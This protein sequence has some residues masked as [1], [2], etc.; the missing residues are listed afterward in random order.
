MATQNPD[1][2]PIVSIVE[3]ALQNGA[4][5]H[6]T[7]LYSLG[8]QEYMKHKLFTQL[9]AEERAYID[10]HISGGR[11]VPIGLEFD[12][13]PISFFNEEEKQ[14][15]GVAIDVLDEIEALVGLDFERPYDGKLPWSELM[16]M[17]ERGE[18]ALVSELIW[19]E[20]RNNRFIWANTAFQT[21]SYALL[22]KT[23]FKDIDFN[24]MLYTKIG[25]IRGAA[26]AELF[27]SWFPNHPNTVIY[28]NTE[29]GFTALERGEI[30]LLMGTQNLLL[31]E[32]NYR[33]NPGYK[34][35][36]VF[37]RTYE[38]LFG[39][40]RG[41]TVL[42]SIVDKSLR[43]IDTDSISDRW[44]RKSFDYRGK[45]LRARMP[46]LIGAS[47]LLLFVLLL[48][49]VLF[50]RK[51]QESRRLERVVHERTRELELQTEAAQVASSA[52][53][54]FLSNMSHEIRT[55]LNAI[56]GMTS[57]AKS[58]SDL[59]R[60]AYCLGKIE[61]ASTHL[62]GIINDILDM[63]KIEANKLEL[64]DAEFDFE[65]M[66]QNVVNVIHFKVEEKR[67]NLAVYIGKDIPH[68]LIGDD[69]RLAQ[70]VANL[71]SNAVKFT[72]EEGSIELHAKLAKEEDGLCTLHIEVADTGIGVTEEQ[73]SRLFT[74]FEQANNNTSRKFGGTGLG[75]AISKRIV[76][77]MG[78]SIWI[79][80]E[81]G[82]G[83]T[84]AFTVQMERGP[85]DHRSH[86]NP[87]VDRKGSRILVVDKNPGS[88]KYVAEII[89]GFGIACDAAATG[90]EAIALIE[91]NGPYS[92]CFIDWKLPGLNGLALAR[93]L[94]RLGE[95]QAIIASTSVSE[96][97][98]VEREAKSAGVKGF[99]SK[100]PFPS[101]LADSINEC[102]GAGGQRLV[103]ETRKADNFSGRRVLLAEDIEVNREIVTTLL[104]PT[105]LKIDCAENGLEAVK[106]FSEYS[107]R[108]GM[109]FMDVQMPEM[110]G[111]EATRR[112]RALEA[113]SGGH[114][115]I[116]AMTANVF[117]E[118]IDKCLEA[119]MDGHVGKPMNF[120]DVLSKLRE[121]LI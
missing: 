67:Q 28:D 99:I 16:G 9:T 30:D 72:P 98:L 38:S 109:I 14:W 105:G 106:L 71:F 49:A 15:Q 11:A 27:L 57:F 108:Y 43:M 65:K 101:S 12:T 86:L 118:D 53:S 64:S 107:G 62:L 116:V 55:P 21:D 77:M 34:A 42:R 51:R 63:S 78:G 102:L 114:I 60:I 96:W 39:F 35:N 50:Q 110:D 1:L 10:E 83:T 119:G 52:K 41:E 79:E 56:I 13:Y 90:E 3:K 4:I 31:S 58:S 82:K 117:R 93:E 25:I 46:W 59:E 32:T 84:F 112:I 97:D 20:E 103:E 120:N 92:I 80:S 17:L 81:Y 91:K 48:L 89:Q 40:N 100:P 95:N 7:N 111:Y 104:E 45:M 37:K 23:E 115:P 94:E 22:S 85:A 87:D 76:E 70:V 88:R 75:L 24:E 68:T 18:V 121:Y 47:A 73:K 33:E 54:D 74:S 5:R 19:S 61:N 29:K 44:M 36:I 69:Q 113:E 2:A 6:L 8:E 26:Y 66:L